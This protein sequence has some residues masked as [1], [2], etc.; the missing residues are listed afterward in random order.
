MPV[1]GLSRNQGRYAAGTLDSGYAIGVEN[2]QRYSSRGT[3]RPTSRNRTWTA[4]SSNATAVTSAATVTTA[5]IAYAIDQPIGRS[6]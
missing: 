5:G 6:W 3:A 4:D 1:I 2:I